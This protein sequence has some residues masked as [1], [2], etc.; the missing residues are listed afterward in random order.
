MIK[1][2]KRPHYSEKPLA[3]KKLVVKTTSVDRFVSENDLTTHIWKIDA[4]NSEFDILSGGKQTIFSQKPEIIM[5]VGD[6]GRAGG[7]QT[8][9]CLNLLSG[10]GYRFYEITDG[11]LNLIRGSMPSRKTSNILASQKKF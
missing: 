11:V 3:G 6:L 8:R 9:D 7:E 1:S 5:E 4:E 10:L 2:E